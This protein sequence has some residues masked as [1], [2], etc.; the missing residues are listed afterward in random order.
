MLSR[1]G[2][3]GARFQPCRSSALFSFCASAP[4]VCFFWRE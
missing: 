2:F 3:E 1:F 4:E